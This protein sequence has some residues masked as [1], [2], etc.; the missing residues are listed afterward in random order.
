VRYWWAD[1][2]RGE[3]DVPEMPDDLSDEDAVRMYFEHQDGKSEPEG[4]EI[5][6]LQVQS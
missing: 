5:T 1:E 2:M 3:A 4:Y 6:R